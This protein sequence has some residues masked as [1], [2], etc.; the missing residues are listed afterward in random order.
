MDNS[1]M[2]IKSINATKNIFYQ[3]LSQK[4]QMIRNIGFKNVYF[5][6]RL[7]HTKE[8]AENCK[9]IVKTKNINGLVDFDRLVN[10]ALL[11]DLGHTPFG[12][13]GE[14]IIN[15]LFLSIDESHYSESFP[16]LFRHNINSIRLLSKSYSFEEEDYILL[17]SVLKHS[18]T[19]PKNYNYRIFTDENILK[20]NYLFRQTGF[21]NSIFLKDFYKSYIKI[22]CKK[23]LGLVSERSTCF[24]CEKHSICHY[25]KISNPQISLSC[26]LRYKFPVTVEGT[27]LYWAD[28]ISCFISDLRDL[29]KF[30]T[31]FEGN[32]DLLIAF[33]RLESVVKL[34]ECKYSNNRLLSL[35][36]K[37]M[38]LLKNKN[39]TNNNKI[40]KCLKLLDVI[41]THLVSSLRVSSI[42]NLEKGQI[43]LKIS[44]DGCHVLFGLNKCNSDVLVRIKNAIYSDVHNITYIHRSN[45]IGKDILKYLI[46]LYLND[47]K[48]F[49]NDSDKIGKIHN[50]DLIE[51]L[52]ESI[53]SLLSIKNRFNESLLVFSKKLTKV[54]KSN[55]F[56]VDNDSL[57]SFNNIS[58]YIKDE[59]K[60]YNRIANLFKREIGYFVASLDENDVLSILRNKSLY[61]NEAAKLLSRLSSI[62]Y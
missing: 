5:T 12:H 61:D 51:S 57:R 10:S 31:Y 42:K 2:A 39:L 41:K 50:K 22:V 7:I 15:D 29:F 62:S 8:V 9:L 32:L 34:L 60:D 53:Y 47:F 40:E 25:S 38:L 3:K 14:D 24:A 6:N 59:N 33:S 54:I 26:Y 28:E 16:G 17:D 27:V 30:L 37:Y 52:V 4:T 18:S 55:S 49:L 19:I 56:K 21:I 43:C 46:K 48:T 1:D 58:V 45:E 23:R 44:K 36:K 35:I 20:M 11:H 13:A